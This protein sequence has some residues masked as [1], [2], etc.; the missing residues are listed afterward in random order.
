M[1]KSRLKFCYTVCQK[2]SKNVVESIGLWNYPSK[3]SVMLEN[4]CPDKIKHTTSSQLSLKKLTLAICEN[5]NNCFLK[6][7]AKGFQNQNK[8]VNQKIFLTSSKRKKNCST[9]FCKVKLR[10]RAEFLCAYLYYWNFG[11]G[12]KHSLVNH[13]KRTY[14][15]TFKSNTV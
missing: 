14:Q 8:V 13:I 5:G 2:C 9:S 7:V 4:L 3:S 10:W 15:S 11:N 6:R 1:S 12:H